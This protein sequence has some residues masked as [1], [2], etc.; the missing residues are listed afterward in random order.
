MA[1]IKLNRKTDGEEVS[2]DDHPALRKLVAD[3]ISKPLQHMLAA[4]EASTA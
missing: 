1:S 3:G 2:V 4:E